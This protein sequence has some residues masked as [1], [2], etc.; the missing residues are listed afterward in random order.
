MRA[1]GRPQRILGRI[2]GLIMARSNRQIAERM[3]ELLEVQPKDRVLEVG[4]GPGV[5][6][7]L[8]A[9]KLSSGKVAGID[10]SAEMMDQATARNAAPVESGRIEL[11]LGSVEVM[12]FK[13][14]TFDKSIGYQLDAGLARCRGRAASNMACLEAT[15][16]GRARLHRL[17]GTSEEGLTAA[18][19][20]AGFTGAHMLGLG[21]DFCVLAVKP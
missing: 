17:F 12:P 4:F 11:R 18:V 3:I 15:W 5:A 21:G 1:F 14:D 10:C 8:I 20:A 13:N 7:Q 2:G 6:L 16:Q 19:A 9:A